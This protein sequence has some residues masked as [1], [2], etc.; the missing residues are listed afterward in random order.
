M[1]SQQ[2][3]L[4]A[5]ATGALLVAVLGAPLWGMVL[6]FGGVAIATKK[7]IDSATS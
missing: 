4:G 3:A 6:A 7:A 5:G 1:T 2:A